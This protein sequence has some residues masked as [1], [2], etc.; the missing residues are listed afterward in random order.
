MRT[1]RM[2]GI[3]RHTHLFTLVWLLANLSISLAPLDTSLWCTHCYAVAASC[4]GLGV[5][6]RQ[7]RR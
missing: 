3:L 6:S 1:H 7:I 5:H 4:V 2:V